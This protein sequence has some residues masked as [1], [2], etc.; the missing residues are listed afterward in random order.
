MPAEVSGRAMIGSISSGNFEKV[1]PSQLPLHHLP[2]QRQPIVR[3]QPDVSSCRQTGGNGEQPGFAF[4]V[5]ARSMG[6]DH[7]PRSKAQRCP[8]VVTPASC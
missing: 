5:P 6:I 4:A 8:T 7:K 2:R 1:H 3:F